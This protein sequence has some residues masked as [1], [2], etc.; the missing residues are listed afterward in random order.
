MAAFC[1][2]IS[3]YRQAGKPYHLPLTAFARLIHYP[4]QK[5]NPC[6]LPHT[7]VLRVHPP[8]RHPGRHREH[9]QR[10]LRIWGG[11]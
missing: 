6:E 11:W 7:D 3:I 5:A 8:A 1:T 2:A 4:V 9:Q 10:Q